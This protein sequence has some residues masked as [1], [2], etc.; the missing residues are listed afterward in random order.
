MHRIVKYNEYTQIGLYNETREYY[1]NDIIS[2]AI[3]LQHS[4]KSGASSS[5]VQWPSVHKILDSTSQIAQQGWSGLNILTWW[6]SLILP[7][8]K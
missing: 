1:I 8:I 7:A 4:D 6:S 5:W 2:F 3:I